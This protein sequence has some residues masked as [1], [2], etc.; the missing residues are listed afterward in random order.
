MLP[1]ERRDFIF[2]YVHENQVA[3]INILASLMS[4]SHMTIRR[5]VEE[6]EREGK[7]TRVSGGLKLNEALRQELAYNDKAQLHHRRKILLG[8]YA[9]NCVEDGLVV[10]LDAG[11]TTFEIARCLAQRFH[12]TVI[13]NDFSISQYLM[14]KPQ[15]NLF[16]IGGEVD[17]RNYSTVGICAASFL[18]SLNIDIAFIS[19]SS[20]DLRHGVSTPYEGKAIVKQ[21]V[22][23]VSR[24]NILISDSSKYGKY[25]KYNIF[26]L[27]E[28]KEIITDSL[29][30]VED[31]VSIQNEGVKLHVVNVE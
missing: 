17:K 31:Q 4:V 6:L 9:A 24:R 8:K 29:L 13:T 30:P 14:D 20:W 12:L 15:V 23:N 7:I 1:T 3:A 27:A 11:T 19:S 10:Y 26:P 2:R 21:A 18:K 5:D 22:I 25:G 16:H 28:I